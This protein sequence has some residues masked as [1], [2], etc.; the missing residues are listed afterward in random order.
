MEYLLKIDF[1][2]NRVISRT[3]AISL[4][5]KRECT[6]FHVS[7]SSFLSVIPFCVSV[8]AILFRLCEL[9]QRMHTL[10]VLSSLAVCPTSSDCHRFW[11]FALPFRARSIVLLLLLYSI[12]M[13]VRLAPCLSLSGARLGL[14]HFPMPALP[15]ACQ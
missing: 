4:D 14:Q 2:L 8:F 5:K 15:G 7:V 12:R 1:S 9:R 11:F 3:A 10:P 13:H 6:S